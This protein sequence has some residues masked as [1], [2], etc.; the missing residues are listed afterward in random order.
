MYQD[1]ADAPKS[2]YYK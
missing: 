1:A 2:P